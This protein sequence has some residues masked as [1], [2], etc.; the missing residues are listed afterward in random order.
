MEG[1]CP[2]SVP[3]NFW[4]LP[5]NG[6]SL[7][8]IRALQFLGASKKE[9]VSVCC[10]FR[11]IFGSFQK[12]DGVCPSSVPSN[13]WE[14]PRNGRS[15]SIVRALVSV[16][17]PFR[18]IFGSFQ[19]MDGVC[20]SSVQ[21]NFRE[22]PNKGRCLSVVRSVLFLGASKK[23][24]ESVHRPCSLIFGS[25]QKME[26]VYRKCPSSVLSNFWELPKKLTES[27]HRPCRSVFGSFQE[28][29]GVCL[30][31]VPSNFWEL[32]KN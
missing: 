19:K 11:P 12:M 15:L 21:S 4:E 18:P 8:I 14:L 1:V 3:S 28:R 24:T 9:T 26:E 30:S 7:S 25:F 16:C 17:R 5:K 10:P 27:V 32:Q 13:F 22:L 20:P 31:F 6:W 2:S 29:D 23:W